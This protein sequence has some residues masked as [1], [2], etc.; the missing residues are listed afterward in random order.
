MDKI[1]APLDGP[2]DSCASHQ[3]T[4]PAAS[5]VSSS[6]FFFAGC[7]GL[8][9]LLLAS[10]TQ[11]AKGS[12]VLRL[13]PLA[14]YQDFLVL[15]IFAWL[16][17]VLYSIAKSTLARRGVNVVA[18]TLIALWAIYTPIAIV[19]YS[20]VRFPLT[21]QLLTTS[22]SVH[23]SIAHALTLGHLI[24]I[25]MM[26]LA[27]FVIAVSFKRLSA[28]VL[29]HMYRG[30]YSR[31]GIALTIVY[32]AGGHA[33]AVRYIH[34]QAVAVNPE[35]AFVSSLFGRHRPIVSDAFPAA[36][37]DDFLPA[38]RQ[39]Q[40]PVI[41][42]TAVSAA[43]LHRP[44]NVIMVVM[45]SV[46]ARRLHLYG[47]AYDDSP[48]LSQ[49]AHHGVLFNRI[50]APE[51]YTSSAMVGLFCSIYNQHSWWT[52]PNEMPTINVEGIAA[53]L[54]THGYRTGFIHDGQLVFD[55][56]GL[57]VRSHGFSQVIG[58]ERDYTAPHDQDLA[59]AAINWIGADSSRPFF[60][61]L[62]TQDAH[63]PY[64][65]ALQRSIVA[66][67]DLNRYL[68]AVHSTDALIGKLARALEEMK[69]ANDTLLVITGDHGEAFG[70]HGQLVH[71]FTVYDE[72]MRV[73]LL[74]VNPQLFP[75]E[76][77]V[78]S[79]GSQI[80]IAPT[81]LSLLRYPEPPQWQGRSLFA[82]PPRPRAYLFA[83]EGNFVLGLVEGDFKY[84]YNFNRNRA[85]L[86][87]L[88]TDPYERDD[89]SSDP[90]YAAMI[91]SD[92][93]RLEAWVSFQNRFIAQFA[94]PSWSVRP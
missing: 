72:E 71:G 64:L 43:S 32:V 23:A 66:D 34:Y 75:R 91:K 60:L 33:L 65:S 81:L 11:I 36:Y 24:D 1:S 27:V 73:P 19:I 39:V 5:D 35:W 2:P 20:Y 49:L 37:A 3:A 48:E 46:G 12:F 78:N 21:Y 67:P 77:V 53:V 7:V 82:V 54:H 58:R 76:V 80:D 41:A 92:H 57:F 86:Y 56:Q 10:R 94:P 29:R 63:H 61:T 88:A 68:N 31:A 74:I 42:K 22:E 16:F 90:Q 51:A 84:I 85:E 18:W 55:N 52:I 45:E 26:P 44:L 28:K 87:D 70:E 38:G 89:L 6:E 17:H 79:L 62:W 9:L 47:A 4:R 8:G 13:L 83:S 93:L 50:Y 25:P 69:L 59:P 30:F 40:L 14:F 15:A